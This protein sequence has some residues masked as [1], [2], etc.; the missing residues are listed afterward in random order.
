LRPKKPRRKENV[1][2]LQRLNKRK[3]KEHVLRP[4]KP[5]RK[6]NVLRPKTPN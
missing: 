2:R 3:K 1:L 4:K 5:K 6:E